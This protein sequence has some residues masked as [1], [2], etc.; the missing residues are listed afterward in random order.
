MFRQTELVG[1]RGQFSSGEN[2]WTDQAEY[3]SQVVKEKKRTFFTGNKQ[4]VFSCKVSWQEIL[5]ESQL[6]NFWKILFLFCEEKKTV[7]EVQLVW[8]E[9][10]VKI[11][12]G[13]GWQCL[14]AR[15]SEHMCTKRQRHR[16]WVRSPSYASARICI[17]LRSPSAFLLMPSVRTLWLM[18]VVATVWRSAA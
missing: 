9:R 16:P 10:D 8:E 18:T 3:F 12:R 15:A 11:K 7:L 1:S 14:W 5:Q 2:V 17:C 6:G 13:G 4:N